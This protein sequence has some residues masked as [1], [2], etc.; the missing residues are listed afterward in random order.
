MKKIIVATDFSKTAT[1]AA[2]YAADMAMAIGA[3]LMLLHIYQVPVI[4]SEAQSAVNIDDWTRDAWAELSILKNDLVTRT[5]GKIN[6]EAQA[7][8]GE[9]FN[10]LKDACETVQ[11]Y[12]VIM[13][14][15]GSTAAERFFLGGHTVNAMRNLNWP[16]IAVPPGVV[17]ASLKKVG[18]ACDFEQVLDT[19]PAEEVKKLVTDFKAEL[20]VLNTGKKTDF[21]PDTV[22]QSGMLQEM[23]SDLKPAYHFITHFDTD[24]GI[25][26]FAEKNQIDLLL[27]LPKRHGLL[28]KLLHK[29]HTKQLVL[30]SHVPVMALHA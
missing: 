6:I 26:D 8:E 2:H 19:I 20:H 25:L 17:F 5:D 27:V 15:Q 7:I 13:G 10:E 12:A 1:N 16:M 11:P 21:D 14:S 23:I 28:D 9:F 4:Y 24:Q 30:H 29:S 3:D 18:L 22:F